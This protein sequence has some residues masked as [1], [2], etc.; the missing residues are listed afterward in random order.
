MFSLV[1]SYISGFFH[2]FLLFLYFF[3]FGVD[4]VPT[5]THKFGEDEK[6]FQGFSKFYEE[7]IAPK[8][9]LFEQIRLEN[10][11]RF[12]LRSRL[13][14]IAL[15][16]SWGCFFYILF[17][18][19]EINKE[20]G[21]SLLNINFILSGFIILWPINVIRKFGLEIKSNLFAEI[22]RFFSFTYVPEG[23]RAIASYECFGII[24]N[25]DESIS[26]TEDLVV[27]NYKDVSFALEELHLKI[28]TGS[29]KRRRRVTKFRG[30]VIMF[31]FNKNFVGR[32]IVK[33]DLGMIGNFGAR[34]FDNNLNDLEK[35]NL[36]DCEFEK[37]FEV[38][39]SDQIE[40]RYL[41]T[42]SFMERLKNL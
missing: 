26:K 37:I 4:A 20:A 11:K 6:D 36:E 27:G 8:A 7:N 30:A 17:H 24:P 38:Y 42:T 40:A 19:D 12:M 13:V 41:L 18:F 3:F 2:N 29:G 15:V 9:L 31:C 28:E 39:S 23:S 14:A 34:K 22:F 25:Y 10:L 1:S 16:A 35:V 5:Q 21:K 33:K 32:T